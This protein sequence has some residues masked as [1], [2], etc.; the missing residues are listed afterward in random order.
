MSRSALQNWVI[1]EFG[2]N[3]VD[4]ASA[5]M[6][7]RCNRLFEDH[8]PLSRPVRVSRVAKALGIRPQ[9]IYTTLIPGMADGSLDVSTG[10]IV[11]RTRG[12]EAPE[13]GSSEHRR[14]RFTYAHELVHA[15][16]YSISGSVLQRIAPPTRSDR[17]RSQEETLCNCGARVLLMPDRLMEQVVASREIAAPD[18]L[19]NV[20][21]AF[22]VNLE[23]AAYR[24]CEWVS[25]GPEESAFWMI[26]K[27]DH[28]GG[29]PRCTVCALTG[30]LTARRLH[31]LAGRQPLDRLEP[32]SG[33][34]PWSL[35]QYVLLEPVR[36]GW[37]ALKLAPNVEVVATETHIVKLRSRHRWL[38]WG[39][40]PTYVWTEGTIEI[41]DE[42][43]RRRKPARQ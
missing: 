18:L 31:L 11:I 14:V 7:I 24:M 32:T 38:K 12:G 36:H 10:R 3:E 20:M 43:R 21:Q 26:S 34:E 6:G 39:R 41:L 17:E 35:L 15:L 13:T 22:E 2:G 25:P 40:K 30:G 9:P 37:D 42:I 5:A 1:Q 33:D 16:F 29:P 19:Y 4:S 28:A 23:P 8:H 27:K